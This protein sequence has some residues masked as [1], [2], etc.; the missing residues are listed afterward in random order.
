MFML[1]ETFCMYWL[2]QNIDWIVGPSKILPLVILSLVLKEGIM[3]GIIFTLLQQ[4]LFNR[5][6]RILFQYKQCQRKNVFIFS[7]FPRL[8]KR[9]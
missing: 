1:Q 3:L 6:V 7:H 5:F 2:I 8:K 4:L 9:D